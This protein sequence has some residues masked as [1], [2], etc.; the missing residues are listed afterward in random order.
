ML[1][2]SSAY[3]VQKNGLLV[4]CYFALAVLGPKSLVHYYFSTVRN[5]ELH[6]IHRGKEDTTFMPR[7]NLR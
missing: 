3:I 6:N 7:S 1:A 2:R 4:D 5:E